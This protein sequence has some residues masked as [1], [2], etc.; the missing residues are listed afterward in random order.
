MT[1]PRGI[2]NKP[3]LTTAEENKAAALGNEPT[4]EP[5]AKTEAAPVVA[6]ESKLV[7][8][9]RTLSHVKDDQIRRNGVINEIE[10]LL[11]ANNQLIA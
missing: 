10:N 1:M 8:L 4:V 3:T 11:A 2:P 6:F 5:E 7:E 9:C